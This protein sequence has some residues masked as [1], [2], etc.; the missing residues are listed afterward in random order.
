MKTISKT[1]LALFLVVISL[2]LIQATSFNINNPT[3][4]RHM[5][6]VITNISPNT[7][8]TTG[9]YTITLTGAGFGTPPAANVVVIFGGF[10][11]PAEDINHVSDLSIEF[12]CPPGVGP[13]KTVYILV[14]GQNSNI[15]L[16]SYG[17]PTISGISPNH[18][19]TSGGTLVSMTGSNFGPPGTG[20]SVAVGGVSS[21]MVSVIDHDSLTFLSPPGAG[22]NRLVTLSIGGLTANTTLFNY[23]P[24]VLTNLSPLFGPTEGGV[25]VTLSGLN[26][27]PPGSNVQLTFNGN[28]VIPFTHIS[29]SQISFTCPEGWGV[30]NPVEL[31]VAGQSSNSLNFAFLPP[32]INSALPSTGPEYG[33]SAITLSGSNFGPPDAPVSISVGAVAVSEIISHSHNSLIF[34]LPPGT[35]TQFINVEISPLISNSIPFTYFPI[36]VDSTAVGIGTTN[37]D[38]S[39]AL[40]IYSEQKGILIPRM[41]TYQR[42]AINAP[43]AGLLVY[44]ST[45]NAFYY[46]NGSEWK[47]LMAE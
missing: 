3:S 21:P 5:M 19:P 35:G 16:F 40:E 29:H 32:T 13:N 27:G 28:P 42:N 1:G 24:P 31:T 30:S 37:P 22:T 36:E 38:P 17:P 20:A 46:Y 47:K 45:E 34:T 14:D 25:L 4:D 33:G 26:F 18:G 2:A 8:P 6:P 43:P 9:G 10:A 12:I 41:S 15:V 23:D 11:I 39:A 44:D 7:G